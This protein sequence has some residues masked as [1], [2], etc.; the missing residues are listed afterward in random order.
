MINILFTKDKGRFSDKFLT[1]LAI[2]GFAFFTS[3][4]VGEEV[5]TEDVTSD[6]DEVAEE[7]DEEESETASE[8]VDETIEEE[9]A[10]AET[11]PIEGDTEED[12]DMETVISTGT[13]L[14]V[15]D[16]TAL[17]HVY[18]AE[19]I[20]STGA[21][22]IDD[23]FRTIPQNFNSTNPQTANDYNS[24]DELGG[25]SGGIYGAF[26]LAS[27]NLQG[28]GSSNTLVLLNGR[29]V[30]GYG[31]SERD[32]VNILGIPLEAI[33]R[34]EI[35][36]DGG[37][38][39]YGA[40][41][42][43]GVVNF[44]T[45]KNYKGFSANFKQENSGTGSDLLSGSATFGLNWPKVSATITLSTNEQEPIINAKTGHTTLDFRDLVGP[46]FDYRYY[47]RSQPGIVREWNG[48]ARYP[49]SYYS[50]YYIDGSFNIDLEKRNFI[51]QLPS[52]HNGLN[53][54]V[55]DFKYGLENI[56]PYNLIS[57]E[58]GA[59]SGRDGMT[60]RLTYNITDD[61]EIFF[62]ALHSE[63]TSE[64][65]FHNVYS[66]S[67]NIV[68]P[69]SNAYNPFGRPMY[70]SYVPGVEQAN[71]I[72]PTPYQ[73]RLTSNDTGTI[74]FRW[75]IEN[76]KLDV[77]ATESRTQTEIRSF[78]VTTS[79][80]RYAPGT[81]EFFRRLSSPDPDEAFNL[82]GN[83]THG[84]APFSDFLGESYYNIGNNRTTTINANVSGFLFEMMGERLSYVIGAERRAI[85]YKNRAVY[86]SGGTIREWDQNAV[87]NGISEPVYRNESLFTELWVPIFGGDL[88]GWY[89]K[90]LQFVIKNIRTI[91]SSWGAIGGFDFNA[92]QVPI[93]VWDPGTTS[94]IEVLGYNYEYGVGDD[95]EYVQ[96]KKGN[97]APN[98]GF[99]YVP[100]DD[101]TVTIN[102]SK[103][104]QPPLISE[105][106]DTYDDSNWFLYDVLDIYDPDGPTLHERIP[107]TY[108]W[109][110]PD[111][112]ASI[113]ENY[114]VRLRY[115]PSY[116][117]GLQ[118][119]I[120][121]VSI[122]F[123]GK[124]DRGIYYADEPTALAY[125]EIAVRNERGDLQS[126]KYD[127]FNAHRTQKTSVD[128]QI[129]YRF[130]TEWLGTL[131]T[132]AH[133]NRILDDYEEPFKGLR[134]ESLGTAAAIDR[135][136]G[137]LSLF[138]DRNQMSASVIAKY[139]PGYLNE[140]A[141]YCSYQQKLN[142]VGRCAQ[143]DIWEYPSWI[144][145]DV[146]S[147]TIVDATFRYSFENNLQMNFGGLNILNRSAPLTVRNRLP[148][149]ATRWNARGR[150][151]SFGINY[152]M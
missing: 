49:G 2:L 146:A 15:P 113:S 80:E 88:G 136:R 131:E 59:H 20:Q 18:T 116:L 56:E 142:K 1:W 123:K 26:D 50:D 85:R 81:E 39:V 70:V 11:D 36:L 110:N 6:E 3:Y 23:F 135:Y 19:D 51:A 120:S 89:G 57:H 60:M 65:K 119:D 149:D 16:P 96:Y 144:S 140:R 24:G 101:L 37:S 139:T 130:G 84:G 22:T 74:G 4:A 30:A 87:W 46:E 151:L 14:P 114:S 73:N 108:T 58:N 41:A 47:Y 12:E 27:A 29:R 52:D 32:I 141:H 91:D 124:I 97:N 55:D 125:D 126:I 8:D 33:D 21:S 45:K 121:Y 94:W 76:H 5:D 145:L 129:T 137:T 102:Y 69:A 105:L 109:A 61:M 40:D 43:A 143:F 17:V 112:K 53:S 117:E 79:R 138:W 34:I 68:V 25:D 111:L 66:I 9:V 127:Y 63:S 100:Y 13:R 82:F 150:V 99:H 10:E 104:V 115:N 107:Y 92:E 133:Y 54:T 31:G 128:A 147:L 118:A 67:M 122:G 38:A 75:E 62:D 90:E 78:R 148:Y 44:I 71:G 64:Q 48:S 42:I 134:F 72:L 95:A 86:F 28:L 98:Y 93:E 7:T 35:Q 132:R 106:Y 83:G 103:N 77:S 152:T